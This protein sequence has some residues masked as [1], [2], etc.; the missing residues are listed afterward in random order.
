[1]EMAGVAVRPMALLLPSRAVQ[2]RGG[3]DGGERS[4]ARPT[5]VSPPRAS[6]PAANTAG[7][8]A[9]IG[10]SENEEEED[11]EEGTGEDEDEDG[12]A[13]SVA[14]EQT[15]S[16]PPT[17][18]L[19]PRG[20]RAGP[21]ILLSPTSLP[22]APAH[23]LLP[24]PDRARNRVAASLFCLTYPDRVSGEDVERLLLAAAE[25]R[26]ALGRGRRGGVWRRDGTGG[27]SAG[28]GGGGSP[29]WP[30]LGFERHVLPRRPDLVSAAVDL[31]G[32]VLGVPPVRGGG[33][34]TERVRGAARG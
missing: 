26:R 18:T 21:H 19:L 28:E 6:P 3:Q 30:L 14:S 1:M 2:R 29:V 5:V 34:G 15:P 27:A 20:G 10:G 32:A 24:W 7:V 23:P 8:G 4:V 13:G 16:S 12:D 25:A 33:G 31:L 22:P 11:A 9:F 17:T